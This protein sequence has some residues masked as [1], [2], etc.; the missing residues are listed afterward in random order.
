MRST[1]ARVLVLLWVASAPLSAATAAAQQNVLLIVADDLGVDFVTG[2]GEGSD[3]APTPTIDAL[4]A[5]GVTFRNAWANPS[6]S[7]TRGC[8]QTGRFPFRTKI[9]IWIDYPSNTHTRGTLSPFEVTIPEVLELAGGGVAHGF[10]GKWH[11]SYQDQG[12]T[13]PNDAGWSH[14][15]GT[16]V[17]QVGSYTNWDYVVNGATSVSTN[18]ITTQ[19]VDDAVQWISA[20]SGPWLCVLSFTAPHLP[21]HVP[22]AHLHTQNLAGVPI[23]NTSRPHYKAVIQ[24]MDTE[25]ARLFQT[26]GPAVMANTNVVFLGDNGSIQNMA[27]PPFLGG[28]AKGT[29]YEGG[30][31]VPLIISG[32]AVV[33]PGREVADLACAVDVYPTVLGLAGAASAIPGWLDLDGVSLLPYVTDTATAPARTWAYSEEFMGSAWPAPLSTGHATIRD[34][35]YKL[36]QRMTSADEF[37]DLAADPF[38]KKNLLTGTLTAGEQQRFTQL[39]NQIAQLRGQAPTFTP[40]GSSSCVGSPGVVPVIVPVGAPMLGQPF[41]VQLSGGVAGGTALHVLGLDAVSWA[42]TYLP[43]DLVA[44]A[45]GGSG[46]DL[47]VAPLLMTPLPVN[48]NGHAFFAATVPSLQILVGVRTFHQWI[49]LDPAAPNGAGIATTSAMTARFGP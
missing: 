16:L 5:S 20:R 9:G 6:C 47:L 36:I 18:Y 41:G 22:P 11:M 40:Y 14:F 28:K 13:V 8:V 4:M 26:L 25:M 3:P 45:A 39:A 30:L 24:A 33:N 15:A 12:P 27:A 32:P 37:Y 23:T 35:R 42:G 19:Q 44:P 38:E 21:M 34:D 49:V 43:I 48:A 10:I 46:C 2:Y 7:P 29:P 1:L 31:N 17:G